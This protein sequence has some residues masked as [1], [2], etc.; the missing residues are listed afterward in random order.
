VEKGAD[1]AIYIS[2]LFLFYLVFKLIVKF[3]KQERDMTKLVREIA[4]KKNK[5]I[6]FYEKK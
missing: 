4:L 5:N 1:L 3:D 2:I 6:D